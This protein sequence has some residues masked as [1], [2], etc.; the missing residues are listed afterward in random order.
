MSQTYPMAVVKTAGK[1]EFENRS[2]PEP[3]A[4]QVLIKTKAVSICGSDVHTFNG[5]HPFAPL[6]AVLGHEILGRVKSVG[7]QVSKVSAGQRVT[8]DPMISCTTRGYPS[9]DAC[10]SCHDG[11]HCTCERA[12]E[13]GVTR[14]Q[15]REKLA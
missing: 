8:I 15:Q 14:I 6:P 9:G 1:V 7:A 10:R 12:G 2:V 11:L 3:T 13:D 5:K 4:G